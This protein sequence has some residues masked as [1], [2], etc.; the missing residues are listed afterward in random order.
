MKFIT[1]GP[2]IAG[3]Q[4]RSPGVG[5]SKGLA[6][7]IGTP[8]LFETG[9]AVPMAGKSQSMLLVPRIGGR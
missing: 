4:I 5:L 6:L 7:Q 2:G 9:S 1:P 8:S 3:S